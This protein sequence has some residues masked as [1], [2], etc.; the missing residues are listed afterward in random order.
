MSRLTAIE[1]TARPG[2]EEELAGLLRTHWA[3]LHELGLVAPLPHWVAEVEGRPGLFLETFSWHDEGSPH[4]AQDNAEVLEIWMRAEDLCTPGGI[5]RL[6]L[7]P[8]S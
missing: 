5:R 4:L 3:R 2:C 7:R 6:L 1:Y 8:L